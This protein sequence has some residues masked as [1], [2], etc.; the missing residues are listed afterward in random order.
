ML[1]D[2]LLSIAAAAGLLTALYWG[3]VACHAV[4]TWWSIPTLRA[5]LKTDAGFQPPRVCVIVP[6]HNEEACIGTV[7]ASLLG[8]DYPADRLSMVFVLDRCSDGTRAALDAAL[9]GAAGGGGGRAAI[10]EID[11]CPEGW[12]G[13]VHA[14]WRAVSDSPAA[15]EADVLLF[16]DADTMMESSCIRA[17]AGLMRSRGLGMLSVLSTLTNDQ[18]FERV[19]QPAA[20]MELVRMFPLR[21]TNWPTQQR[22]FANGQFIMID[23]AAYLG[24]GGHEAVRQYVLEDVEL[25]RA[26][27]RAGVRL[28]VVL[29][30]GLLHCRMY[31]TWADFRRG[32]TR[33]FTESAN[34]KVSRLVRIAWRK[35]LVSTLLPLA[36]AM[37]L[38]AGAAALATGQ[39]SEP[40]LWAL[41]FGAAGTLVYVSTLVLCMKLGRTPLRSA[42]VFPIGAWMVSDILL[43]CARSLRAG[44]PIEWAGRVYSREAR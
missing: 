33:I 8:Q 32:W 17:A 35:R 7:A 6:A 20:G 39:R 16:L 21:R 9:G 27:D 34:R 41:R 3:A 26:A 4:R 5:G 18:W 12:A 23:R 15:R 14:L 1:I 40:A 24:F 30:D 25:A 11:H 42:A 44:K 2:T 29:A 22:P 10:I 37:G 36:G 28:G 38:L 13:K 43:G 19:V 31:G